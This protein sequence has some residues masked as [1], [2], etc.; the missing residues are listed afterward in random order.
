MFLSY[1]INLPVYKLPDLCLIEQ[2]LVGVI[3]TFSTE[4]ILKQKR[5]PLVTS[6]DCKLY[7]MGAHTKFNQD[8]MC[9]GAFGVD[10]GKETVLN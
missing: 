8:L 4:L 7:S 6:D 9:I 2:N 5:V 1:L 3:P 10:N